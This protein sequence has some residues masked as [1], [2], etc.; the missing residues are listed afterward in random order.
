MVFINSTIGIVHQLSLVI[1][2]FYTNL[3]RV[4]FIKIQTNFILSK[5]H[6][7]LL[8]IHDY[9]RLMVIFSGLKSLLFPIF[10]SKL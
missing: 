2:S 8:I 7:N 10:V 1:L 6:F 3:N 4:V 5:N 9:F